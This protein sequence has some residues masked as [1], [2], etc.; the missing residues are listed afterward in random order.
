MSRRTHRKVRP[1]VLTAQRGLA[2]FPPNL[3]TF[4]SRVNS[5]YM[6]DA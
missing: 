6:E 4:G 5:L 1:F 2:K 3:V